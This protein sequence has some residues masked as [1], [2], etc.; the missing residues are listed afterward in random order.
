MNWLDWIWAPILL[1]LMRLI[2]GVG[3]GGGRFLSY[4]QWIGV[5]MRSGCI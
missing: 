3:V 2:Q 4:Y 1:V 5:V